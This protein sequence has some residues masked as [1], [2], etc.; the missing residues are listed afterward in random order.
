MKSTWM[1]PPRDVIAATPAWLRHA[2]A[3]CMAALS[4]ASLLWLA[5]QA[6]PSPPQKPA[7]IT[8]VSLLSA[9]LERPVLPPEPPTRRVQ[10]ETPKLVASPPIPAAP[11]TR[12]AAP[13]QAQ[14]PSASLSAAAP[15][16][17]AQDSAPTSDEPVRFV[18]DPH[19]SA[20]GFGAVAQDG[21][22][23][24]GRG[25]TPAAAAPAPASP[26]QKSHAPYLGALARSPRPTAFDPCRGFFPKAA[27]AER[28]EAQM[29][30][31][32]SADGRVVAI[33]VLDETPKAQGFGAAARTCLSA[34]RFEPARDLGGR[35]VAVVAPITVKFSR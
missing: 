2:L 35:A 23:Q 13:R 5:L 9:A 26:K 6:A 30:V 34:T 28:G 10:D 32:V 17:T 24:E 19:G 33:S 29:H 15:L 7:A 4:H 20:F 3:V 8:E 27:H 31:T 12:P 25:A 14:S 18:T 16:R 1:D 22:A 11:R 21:T